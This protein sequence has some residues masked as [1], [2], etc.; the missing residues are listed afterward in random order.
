[1][2]I[3]GAS[4]ISNNMNSNCNMKEMHG[5]V[6]RKPIETQ[7]TKLNEITGNQVKVNNKN[8]VSGNLLDLRA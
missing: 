2:Q 4:G 5:A 1:M 3:K 6:D 8:E 7:K